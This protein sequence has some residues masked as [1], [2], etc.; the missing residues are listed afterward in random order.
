MT[1]WLEHARFAIQR[2]RV[3][4]P[5]SLLHIRY[6]SRNAPGGALRDDIKNGCVVD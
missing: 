5:P 1:E 6:T 3:Q 4:V 2:P